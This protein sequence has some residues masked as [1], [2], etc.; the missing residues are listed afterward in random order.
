M[1]S[2]GAPERKG[3]DH[4]QEAGACEIKRRTHPRVQL[5]SCSRAVLLN[6][7][8]VSTS[9]PETSLSESCQTALWSET[10]NYGI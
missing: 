9:R 3:E 5:G 4:G 6:K 8:M 10:S 1:R 2:Q 7:E